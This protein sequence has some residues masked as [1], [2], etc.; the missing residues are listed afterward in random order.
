V[1]PGGRERTVWLAAWTAVAVSLAVIVYY[2]TAR[3]SAPVGP[4]MANAGNSAANAGSRPGAPPD[5]SQMSPSERFLRLSDRVMTAAQSGDSATAARFAPMAIA[6][7]GM[8]DST[9]A[10]LRYHAGALYVQTGAYQAAL[11]LADTIQAQA[12]DNLLGDMLRLEVAQARRDQAGITRYRR[13]FL[14]H[15]DRQTALKRPEY[16]EHREM[17][18]GLRKQLQPN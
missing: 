6:A 15:Y 5:I 12:P 13:A 17:L 3:S 8:L 4:D 14:D 7:Y 2:V 16:L 18:E 1:A 11:A 10:D 9:S